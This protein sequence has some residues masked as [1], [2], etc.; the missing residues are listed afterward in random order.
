MSIRTIAIMGAT[1]S[2][3]SQALD[4]VRRWPERFRATCLTAHASSEK[5]FDPDNEMRGDD[6]RELDVDYVVVTQKIYPTPDLSSEDYEKV[7]SN[8]DIDI[9]KVRKD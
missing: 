9:Y 8:D 2:I 6:A 1:G 5:L 3:G 4:I 7:F